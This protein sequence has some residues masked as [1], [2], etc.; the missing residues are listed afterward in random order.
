MT[1]AQKKGK[2]RKG[3]GQTDQDRSPLRRSFNVVLPLALHCP[4]V[5]STNRV[6]KCINWLHGLG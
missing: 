6:M 5:V 1:M 2:E 3:K 4:F